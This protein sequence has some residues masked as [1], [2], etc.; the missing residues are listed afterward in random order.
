MA[1]SQGIADALIRVRAQ[2]D[3]RHA[4]IVNT[5][6]ILRNDRQLLLKTGWL[7]EIIR[8]WYMLTRPDIATGDTAAWDANFWDFVKI[9]LEDRFGDEYCLSAESSLDLHVENPSTPKQVI[10]IAKQGAG[11]RTLMYDT[12]LLIYADT[13]NFPEERVEKRNINV[14]NLAYAL[15]KVAPTYFRNNPRDAEIALKSLKTVDDITRVII[16]YDLKTAAARI[17]GAYQFLQDDETANKIKNDLEKTGITVTPTNPFQIQT[18]LLASTRITSPY[19]GRIR[20][21]WVQGRNDVIANFPAPPGIPHNKDLYMQKIED[22]Y[23]YDAYNSLSIE[24]YQVTPELIN[25]VKNNDWNPDFNQ[26]DDN[27]KNAMAAKGYY[28]AFQQVKSCISRIID[29]E[30]AAKIIKDNLQ[31]WYQNLFGPSAHAGIIPPESLFG[32]RNDRV[33]IR[34]SRHSPPPKEAVVDAMEA[35]FDCMANETHPAVNAILGHYFFVYIHPYM[36]GNGR[37]ARFIMNAA[38]ASG[39]YPW[40]VVRVANRKKY[41]SILEN[42]HLNFN[43]TDFTLFIHEEMDSAIKN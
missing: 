43:M 35:F 6:D 37:I 4:E 40:A 36:D 17:I 27:A 14:M 18:P 34:N 22:L 11:L 1:T 26:F 5:N 23:Q 19:T 31:L 42:T 2:A 29:G 24:G 28:D 39:G 7:Q 20:A 25:R 10:V 8:G 12:S 33:Y 15:C 30:N 16:K 3:S 9:Y 21:M 13:K 38:L 41:I 32:Y